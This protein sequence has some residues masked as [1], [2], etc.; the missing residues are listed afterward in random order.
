[1]NSLLN[2]CPNDAEII[3][4]NDGSVD[5]SGEICRAYARR[6]PM[7]RLIEKPNGGVSTARN[8]GL[9]AARGEYICFVDSDDYVR[10]DFFQEMK[11]TLSKEE[12]DLVCFSK[13]V[14]D[15]KLVRQWIS[16][17][18]AANCRTAAFTRII[19]DICSKELN[20]P[21]AK[22]YR[23]D[24]IER[25]GIRFPIGASVAEDRAF[26]IS[27][28]IH[29]NSYLISERVIYCVNTQNGQSLSRKQ[30]ADLDVQFQI[31]SK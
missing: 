25:H 26:N 29:V 17:A 30:Y 18:F 10:P 13:C 24:I 12:W 3:L 15:G 14:D 23:R 1:M 5:S 31:V 28:S 22:V 27:Y 2:S 4:I 11:D 7:I 21:V 20:G 6:Y 8:A 9:D 19:D 16:A